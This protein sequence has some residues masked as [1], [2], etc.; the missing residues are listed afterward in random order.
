MPKEKQPSYEILRVYGI[1]SFEEA[2]LVFISLTYD[3]SELKFEIE[4]YDED[5][6]GIVQFDIAIDLN[7]LGQ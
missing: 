2:K 5:E 6:H 1:W 3:E 4:E 7:S